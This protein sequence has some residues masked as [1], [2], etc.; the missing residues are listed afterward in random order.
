VES[1]TSVERKGAKACERKISGTED[2]NVAIA[3]F[4]LAN[5][6]VQ[7][8]VAIQRSRNKHSDGVSVDLG[9]LCR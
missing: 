4:V 1:S 9:A 6:I 7:G 2:S 8:H 3:H 5:N